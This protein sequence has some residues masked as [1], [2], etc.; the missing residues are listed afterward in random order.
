VRLEELSH[1]HTGRHAERVQDDFDRIAVGHVGH[2]GFRNEFCHNA[3]VSVTAGHLVAHLEFAL[4]GHVHFHL[5]DDAW[6]ELG[7]SLSDEFDLGFVLRLERLHGHFIFTERFFELDVHVFVS[8]EKVFGFFVLEIF[9]HL[10]RD[11]SRLR[12]SKLPRLS[13]HDRC[14]CFFVQQQGANL[15]VELEL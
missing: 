2:V 7:V 15:L 8:H 6:I 11:D 3:L 1:V 9:D 10:L 13:V 12:G 5:A 14:W 4:R